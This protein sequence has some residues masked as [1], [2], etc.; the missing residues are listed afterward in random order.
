MWLALP[1]LQPPLA[2]AEPSSTHLAAQSCQ[3]PSTTVEVVERWRQGRAR[4]LVTV[5]LVL[6]LLLLLLLLVRL[7]LL[8]MLLEVPQAVW[9]PLPR[10]HLR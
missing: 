3:L 2:S 7:L 10:Q 8:L 4:L 9:P 5:L 1:M 6:L